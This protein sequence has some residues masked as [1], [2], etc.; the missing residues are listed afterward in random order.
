[1]RLGFLHRSF[2]SALLRVRALVSRR[3]YRVTDKANIPELQGKLERRI[4]I[5]TET[6]KGLAE[7]SVRADF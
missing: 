1:L 6:A 4:D 5:V 7:L 3:V 2:A